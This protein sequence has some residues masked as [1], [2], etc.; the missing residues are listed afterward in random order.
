MRPFSDEIVLDLTQSIAGPFATQLL[1]AMGADV[2]KVEPPGGDDFRGLLGGAM[3][4][5]FNLG[6]KRSVC[7]DLKTEEGRAAAADL[8]AGA[9][10]IIE[11]FRPG[12]VKKFDLNY[13]SVRERNEDIV[14]CSISGFGQ[15]GPYSDRPAYD[16]VLQSMSGL[17]STIGYPDRP[18]VRIGASVIDCGTGMTAAFAVAAAL[19]ERNR[20]G[21]GERVEVSLFEVA[22][23]W[24]AYW[25]AH[26]SE[27]CE[28][29]ERSAR[30]GFVGLTPNG[31]F[32]AGDGEQLY[33]SVISD[34]QFERLCV[35]LDREDLATDE[36]FAARE[37]R[38]EH[39][40][41][42]LATLSTVFE[43][44]NRDNLVKQLAA[45][46]VPAGPLHG[47]DDIPDDPHVVAR[48]LLTETRNLQTDE[49]IE[50]AG[51]PLSTDR[52][53]PDL[54]DRPPELGEHPRAVLAGLG[55]ST[56]QIERMLAA[57]SAV[58]E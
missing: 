26:Y 9:D 42:L 37:D 18:P 21:E 19:L 5:S 17:M 56:E 35:A 38:W 47:V 20:T 12:V 46:G 43:S 39:H 4:A 24:M 23:S 7:L 16:P 52:G 34:A 28:V 36:R 22:V 8:A 49:R 30:G 51:V 58:E 6:H 40:E 11:S 50:T 15:D 54:G 13:A 10:V 53:R 32:E 29:P 45:A 3:F 14:Y 48:E 41:E 44:Y 33:V 25:I 57:G 27:T 1:G 31:V 55:Y 2:V